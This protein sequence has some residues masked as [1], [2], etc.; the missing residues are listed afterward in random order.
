MSWAVALEEL[1]GYSD[2]ER[3]KWKDW[4]R[5]DLV[6]P[7]SAASSPTPAPRLQHRR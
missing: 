4:F 7:T 2:H 6:S 3:A 1:I 5:A